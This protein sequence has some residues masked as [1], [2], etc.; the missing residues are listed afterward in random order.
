MPVYKRKPLRKDSLNNWK[1][2]ASDNLVNTIPL[3]N[4]DSSRAILVKNLNKETLP[5][6]L[7]NYFD[8]YEMVEEVSLNF[9]DNNNL[10]QTAT[11]VFK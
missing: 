6:T 4:R 2:F 9:D 5:G 7:M 3:S 10:D 11:V 8:K 1:R